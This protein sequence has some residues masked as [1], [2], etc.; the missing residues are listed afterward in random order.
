MKREAHLLLRKACD[1]LMLS[2]EFFNRPHDLGRAT[3]TLILLG[4]TFEMLLKA[5]IVVNNHLL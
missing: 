2:M 1:S 3:T 5:S 4:H